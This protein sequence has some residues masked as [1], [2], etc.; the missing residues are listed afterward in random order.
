MKE[1]EIFIALLFL[2]LAVICIFNSRFIAKKR[3]F[4]FNENKTV[5][6]IKLVGY[7]VCIF[8]LILMYLSK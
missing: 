3:F 2:F 4:M 1:L 8:S 5:N 6:V 7:C